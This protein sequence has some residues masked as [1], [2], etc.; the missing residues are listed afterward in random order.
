[1]STLFQ[2]LGYA[3]RLAWRRPGLTVV[4]ILTLALG[5]GGNSAIF[6]LINGLFLR[7]LPVER[8]SELVRVFGDQDGNSY[9]V[10]SYANLS[11]IAAQSQTFAAMAIHQ[12]TASSYGLGDATEAA[13][14]ELVSS[15]Y[16]SMLGLR[17]PM[18]RALRADDDI[19]GKPQAVAVIS[20]AW[21]KTR[22]GGRPGVIGETIHLNAA[23]FTVV[24]VAPAT[25]RGSYDALGTDLWVPLMTYEIVRPRGLQI[26]RR[27]WGWLTATARLKPGVSIDQAQ[28]DV[29][30]IAAAL[31]TDFPQQNSGLK[32]RLV[33][34]SAFLEEMGPTVQ[35]VLLFALIVAGLALA[36]ACANVANVQLA[37]VFDR[38]REIA[39]RLAMGASRGRIARQWLTESLLV[40][41][42]AA[43]VGTIGAMWVRDAASLFGPPE[44]LTN[45]SPARDFDIRLMLFS[46]AVVAAVTMLFGGWPAARAARVD[47]A[48]PLKEDT[49]TSTGSARR[50]WAQAGLVAAQVAVSVALVMSS[51][52]L[53]RSLTAANAFDLGFDSTNLFIATPRMA[54][55]GM[56]AER[57]RA[58]YDDTM[59]RVR[60]LPG[61]TDVTL[62]AVVPLGFD[63]ES[64]SIAIDGYSPPDGKGTVSIA[65]NIVAPNYFDTMRIP[66]R[67]GR[68]FEAADGA[69]SAPAVAVVNETMS[70]RF[71]PD[72]NPIGR[73]LRIGNN[74]PVEIVGIAADI[75]YRTAGEPP[76]P[77]FYLPFGPVPFSEG[78]S[79]HVRTA[80]A[81]ASLARSMRRELRVFEPRVQVPTAMAYEELRQQGLYPGR[82]LAVVSTGFGVIAL[83]LAIVG[84]YG[85]MAHVV[86]SRRR[87]FAVRLALGAQPGA[88][89]AGV[90]RQGLRWSAAGIVAGLALA[91]GLAQLL[92]AF[93]FD[94]STADTLSL[95]GSAAVLIAVSLAAAYAPARRVLR[96]DPAA[97]LR[98]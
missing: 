49:V 68:G 47:V 91:V 84:I 12:Q 79:F 75:T 27:G 67:R 82:A 52:L 26:T 58:Y 89:V 18:G 80:G 70:R 5:I 39:V 14:I 30:R 11:D 63:N 69:A 94:V 74:P 64:R 20:D 31:R 73:L 35:R 34:A 1:M 95:A 24:G 44:G 90:M 42:A 38:R 21:W 6:S 85:V 60:A 7:P 54:N 59:A 33:P 97:T 87:E 98:G 86:A 77:F 78:L 83:L 62:G 28:A 65:T 96:I 40:A 41:A 37:T 17:M 8:P 61:V 29:D 43:V 15:N 25:F 55:L 3:V 45:F 51:A 72:Q 23:P 88:L 16:F 56:N 93:L 13:N 32:L 36:A 10:S 92:K 71:W 19:E 81:D 4:T 66:I 2:D 76:R 9:D 46:T 48:G 53:T 22:L 57:S 50:A